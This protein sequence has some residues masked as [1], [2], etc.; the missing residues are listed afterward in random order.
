MNGAQSRSICSRSVKSTSK[1]G[2]IAITQ[3]HWSME[4]RA[5]VREGT[6]DH[7]KEKPDFARKMGATVSTRKKAE[8]E[9]VPRSVVTVTTPA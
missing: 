6:L 1:R 5:L 3:D 8:C 9:V 7:Y 2:V 4:G